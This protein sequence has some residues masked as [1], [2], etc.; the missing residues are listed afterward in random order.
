MLGYTFFVF[1]HKSH[2][3]SL[4][5]KIP[6]ELF[7]DLYPFPE[8][9]FHVCFTG[10]FEAFYEGFL[11]VG[12]QG[13]DIL[14]FILILDPERCDLVG[15]GRRRLFSYTRIH[16]RSLGSLSAYGS[17]VRL[18]RLPFRCI[19]DYLTHGNTLFYCT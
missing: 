16:L 18:C 9:F 1:K 13:P 2:L 15:G 7:L 11:S 12:S 6:L 14:F 17:L 5:T 19:T 10:A 3:G 4:A 8:H